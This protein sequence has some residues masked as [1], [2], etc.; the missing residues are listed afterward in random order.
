MNIEHRYESFKKL[1][2]AR[3]GTN[4]K[5]AAV[6]L[7]MLCQERRI[8]MNTLRGIGAVSSVFALG[9]LRVHPALAAVAIPASV[10]MV[11]FGMAQADLL[12]EIIAKAKA[13]S[14]LQ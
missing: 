8:V 11:W 7:T 13:D 1:A 12:A 10:A 9:L 2:I 3:T 4:S 5:P 6:Y 14:D